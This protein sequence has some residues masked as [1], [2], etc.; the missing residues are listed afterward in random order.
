MIIQGASCKI[1]YTTSSSLPIFLSFSRIPP[2]SLSGISLSRGAGAAVLLTGAAAER[3]RGKGGGGPTP[4]A[5]GPRASG[6]GRPEAVSTGDGA[7]QEV[8]LFRL[9]RVVLFRLL[10]VASV[11]SNG[12]KTRG[13][14]GAGPDAFSEAPGTPLKITEARVSSSLPWLS[15]ETGAGFIPLS[16]YW[17]KP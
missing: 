12:G 4:P 3:A 15:Q 1:S 8:L 13:G 10:R 2:L 16:A 9:L 17:R 6:G 5:S 11:L 7:A 14:P